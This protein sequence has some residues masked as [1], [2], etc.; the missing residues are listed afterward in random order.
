MEKVKESKK[1]DVLKTD[2]GLKR[3]DILEEIEIELRLR[4]LN[5]IIMGVK[6]EGKDEDFVK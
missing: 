2:V 3:D 5:L 4:R 6:E 1:T